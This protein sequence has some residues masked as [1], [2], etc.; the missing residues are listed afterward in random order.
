MIIR[1]E[2]CR[3]FTTIFFIINNEILKIFVQPSVHSKR[4]LSILETS[5][6]TRHKLFSVEHFE[7]AQISYQEIGGYTRWDCGIFAWSYKGIYVFRDERQWVDYQCSF[8][9]RKRIVYLRGFRRKRKKNIFH[10]SCME[11]T[12]FHFEHSSSFQRHGFH[13]DQENVEII[14]F[15]FWQKYTMI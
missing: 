12:F 2:F 4:L 9:S 10:L 8:V 15:F 1:K 6:V 3:V 11:K 5:P 13:N 7:R 14:S